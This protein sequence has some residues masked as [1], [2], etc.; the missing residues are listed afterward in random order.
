MR[1]DAI[2]HLEAWQ[3]NGRFPKIHDAITD[4]AMASLRGRRILDLGCSY[5]LLGTRLRQNGLADVVVGVDASLDVLSDA[6]R[7]GI[8]IMARPLRVTRES[9]PQLLAW[10]R[11][12]KLDAIVARRILPELFGNDLETGRL[13]GHLVARAGIKEMIIEGRVISPNAKNPLQSID[14]EVKMLVESFREV[15]RAGAVSYLVAR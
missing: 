7:A 9:L 1:Y 3:A 10:V 13:F 12:H 8:P 6:L 11:E 14:Q 2:E 4:M 15:K 5:G